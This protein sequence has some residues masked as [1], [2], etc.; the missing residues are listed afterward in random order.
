MAPAT[1]ATAAAIL[2][3]FMERTPDFEDWG[4]R[5]RIVLNWPLT[6]CSD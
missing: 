3:I 4:S 1:P 6:Y 5:R 2:S